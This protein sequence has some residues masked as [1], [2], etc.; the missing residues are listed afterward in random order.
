MSKKFNRSAARVATRP[1]SWPWLCL[2]AI[3]VLS[4]IILVSRYGIAIA[5][6]SNPVATSTAASHHPTSA[7]MPHTPIEP[8]EPRALERHESG[9]IIRVSH[10]EPSDHTPDAFG[11]W[12]RSAAK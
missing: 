11:D 10:F 12:D 4:A 7:L 5:S 1:N 9:F 3:V 8:R 6:A 2:I